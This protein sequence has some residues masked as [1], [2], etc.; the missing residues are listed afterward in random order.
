MGMAACLVV[1]A[2]VSL[3]LYGVYRLTLHKACRATIDKG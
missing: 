1:V 2:V 3:V